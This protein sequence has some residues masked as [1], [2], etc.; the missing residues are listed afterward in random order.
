MMGTTLRRWRDPRFTRWVTSVVSV[1]LLVAVS[2]FLAHQHERGHVA[3]NTEQTCALCL[4]L[5]NVGA[6]P[7]V[8]SAPDA[9]PPVQR[10]LP[11][12]TS[13]EPTLRLA[14]SY[15]SRAPPRS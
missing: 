7:A 12:D 2:A 14:H 9:L 15:R 6:A 1:A 3:T 10:L 4:Q 11:A 5:T 8:V 13:A